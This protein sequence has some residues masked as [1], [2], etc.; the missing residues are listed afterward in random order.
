MNRKKS[1]AENVSKWKV[2]MGRK[3]IGRNDDYDV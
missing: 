3:V 2:W 1:E